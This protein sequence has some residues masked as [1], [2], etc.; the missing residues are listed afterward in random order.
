MTKVGEVETDQYLNP[1]TA[2]VVT[3]DQI[4]Q[5]FHQLNIR[6]SL[7]TFVYTVECIIFRVYN[8]SMSNGVYQLVMG[9]FGC[10]ENRFVE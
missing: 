6:P 7:V 1:R 4:K 10:M 2:Q 8:L 5:V 9:G 3:V